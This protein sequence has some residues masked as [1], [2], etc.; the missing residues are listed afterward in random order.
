M[1]QK[2]KVKFMASLALPQHVRI[3]FVLISLT[4]LSWLQFRVGGGVV[5]AELSQFMLVIQ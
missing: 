4:R 1:F 2:V 5:A 3:F